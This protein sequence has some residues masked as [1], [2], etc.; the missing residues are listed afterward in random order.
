[1]NLTI[2]AM[3]YAAAA[4]AYFLYLLIADREHLRLSTMRLDELLFNAV[5]SAFWPAAVALEISWV[6]R[7]RP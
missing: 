5:V 7:G 1:M 2:A 3:V 6:R 4:S